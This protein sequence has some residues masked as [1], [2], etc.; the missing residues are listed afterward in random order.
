[1]TD[2]NDPQDP[3]LV[4][5][6]AP[7]SLQ[8][9][10]SAAET[11]AK[12]PLVRTAFLRELLVLLSVLLVFQTGVVQA[13]NVP[14]GSME[15]T[16]LP[17]DFVIADKLTLGPRTPH[18]I[19]IPGTSV[20]AHLP[21]FKLPGLRAVERGDIVVVE[22]PVDRQTPYLKRVVALGGDTVV[23]RDKR[24]YVNGQPVEEAKRV[25][26]ADGRLFPR[27]IEQSG[28]YEGLGNRDNFGP[29]VVPEG[30]AFLMGDNRDYSFDS[31]F[32][33]PVATDHI[34]GRARWVSFSV[35]PRRSIKLPW[36]RVRWARIGRPLE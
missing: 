9:F 8:Q 22:V 4:P 13:F 21:A 23:V 31:R 19:G 7:P 32:F 33:G 10:D 20:G 36:Q 11:P 2:S 34:I 17:G 30:Q 25:Q 35:D 14:T 15:R 5:G 29:L 26:H 27:G 18:W 3:G 24:L 1:M 28:T 12:T 6:D 16:V